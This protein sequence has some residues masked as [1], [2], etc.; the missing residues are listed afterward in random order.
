MPIRNVGT[1][2]ENIV[3][4]EVARLVFEHAE[5]PV[6]FANAFTMPP[7]SPWKE[8]RNQQRF[9]AASIAA[10]TLDPTP[11]TSYAALLSACCTPDPNRGG[12][13]GALLVAML[14]RRLGVLVR[15]WLND[16]AVGAH[17]DGAMVSLGRFSALLAELEPRGTDPVAV[18][19]CGEP[20]PASLPSLRAALDGWH[21]G[22]PMASAMI[23]FLDPNRYRIAGAAGPETSSPDHR[24]WLAALR[25]GGPPI[26]VSV[27][28]TG[29]NH[30]PTL[31]PEIERLRQDA[32][33]EGYAWSLTAMHSHYATIVS[34]AHAQP[35]VA[36]ALRRI[37]D[38]RLHAAWNA[39]CGR[40]ALAL[41][42]T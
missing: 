30:W 5:S 18:V 8:H 1:L 40:D 29:H 12:P 19:T 14:A 35:A 7:L 10:R 31:R 32:A 24:R 33:D 25:S 9:D 17:Y 2:L 3:L 42:L 36:E 34:L 21:V 6:D 23:G 15:F 37:L 41:T 20:Y 28:F 16:L 13:S 39:W 22:M 4:V 11:T 38:G 27:H 26:A